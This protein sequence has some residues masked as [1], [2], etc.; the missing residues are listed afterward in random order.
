[1]WTWVEKYR[2]GARLNNTKSGPRPLYVRTPSAPGWGR[3]AS[4]V[5]FLPLGT[6]FDS[7]F[8]FIINV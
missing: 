4:V 1:M 5:R 8:V 7:F 2:V 6:L 3:R